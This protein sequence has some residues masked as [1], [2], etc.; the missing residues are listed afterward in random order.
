[1]N[2][3]KHEVEDVEELR[4]LFSV[5]K[6]FIPEMIPFIKELLNIVMESVSGEKLGKDVAQFYKNLVESGMDE[7]LAEELTKKYLT[8]KLQFITDSIGKVTKIDVKRENEE[9]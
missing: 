6:E 1:M 7:K 9:D 2:V 8:Q 5:L 4:E 3:E